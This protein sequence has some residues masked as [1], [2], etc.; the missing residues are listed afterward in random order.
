[1]VAR[2]P[3]GWTGPKLWNSEPIE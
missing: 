3:K 2:I 1:M